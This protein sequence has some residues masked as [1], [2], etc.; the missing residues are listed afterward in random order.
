MI[1]REAEAMQKRRTPNR[2]M[3]TDA[4]WFSIYTLPARARDGYY[5]KSVLIGPLKMAPPST[6]LIEHVFPDCGFFVANCQT[7]DT[8]PQSKAC[9]GRMA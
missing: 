8:F 4:D 7:S 9:A 2:R 6:P 5:A 3:R 1:E